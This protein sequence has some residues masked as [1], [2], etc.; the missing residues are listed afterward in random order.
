M[1]EKNTEHQILNDG[2]LVCFAVFFYFTNFNQILTIFASH[3]RIVL[4]SE[5]EVKYCESEDHATS[6]I[7]WP[8]PSSVCT[9]LPSRA[10]HI[11]IVLSA[12]VRSG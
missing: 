10:F 5:A 11:L 8:W 9:N 2:N 3:I 4:S 6:E 7:P 1:G 12:A